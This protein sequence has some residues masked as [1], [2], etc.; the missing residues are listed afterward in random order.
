MRSS[1]CLC[2]STERTPSMNSRTL[3]VVLFVM[4]PALGATAQTTDDPTSPAVSNAQTDQAQPPIAAVGEDLAKPTRGFVSALGHNLADDVKHIPRRN[5][6][7]WLGGGVGLAL[8]VHPIDTKLNAHLVSH[9][10]PF[11]AGELIG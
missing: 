10:N 1:P 6:L 9:S 4:A 8:A 2:T 5:S 11:V 3:I 7:Y